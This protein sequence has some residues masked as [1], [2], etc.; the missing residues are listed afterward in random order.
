ML[1]IAHQRDTL[2]HAS[3]GGGHL[4]VVGCKSQRKD[5]KDA[6]DG[7]WISV[8]QL[9][10]GDGYLAFCALVI[11]GKIPIAKSTPS[12]PAS[13]VVEGVRQAHERDER[14]GAARS[15][16]IKH[17]LPSPLRGPWVTPLLRA[18][19]TLAEPPGNA[20]A[21]SLLVSPCW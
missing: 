7:R 21:Q 12:P 16:A 8:C 17:T 18:P 10:F 15:L 13:L 19:S 9:V 1:G 20:P 3:G 6:L 5:M 14:H 11:Q 4:K 2:G